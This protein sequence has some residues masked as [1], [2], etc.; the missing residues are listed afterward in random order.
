M[1]SLAM[2]GECIADLIP[3]YGVVHLQNALSEDEQKA[4]WTR[5]KPK[6]TDPSGKAT[7]FAAFAVSSGKSHRDEVFDGY[8]ELLFRRSAEELM[9]QMSEEDCKQ[10]PSYRRLSQIISG[11]KPVSL[12]CVAGNYYRA[13]ATLANHCDMNKPFFTMSVALGDAI[14]FTVGKKTQRPW[15][16]ERSGPGKTLVMKSGDAVF[17]DGGSVP[18][19]VGKILPGTAPSW[20]ESNKVPNGA[21]C[22]LLFRED[23]S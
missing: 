9:K 18:H 22:V 21:R 5:T 20:W 12:N 13:D 8:G 7:G 4:L 23:I 15:K 16:N 19:E 14:E 11:E 2:T 17:F 10:E 1:E 3:E 6:V